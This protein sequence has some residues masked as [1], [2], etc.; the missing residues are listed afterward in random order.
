M[1]PHEVASRGGCDGGHVAHRMHH[2]ARHRVSSTVTSSA[3][4]ILDQVTV[5]NVR[6][7]QWADAKRTLLD[8]GFNVTEEVRLRDRVTGVLHQDPPP[9]TVVAPGSNVTLVVAR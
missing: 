1:L 6:G 4:S 9:G 2:V 8:A 7:M 3:T 5:P